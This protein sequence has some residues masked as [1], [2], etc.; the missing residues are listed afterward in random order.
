MGMV[1][2]EFISCEKRFVT[3]LSLYIYRYDL[4]GFFTVGPRSALVYFIIIFYQ[5]VECMNNAYF[6]MMRKQRQ[7]GLKYNKDFIQ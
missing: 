7:C 1:D 3:R 5:V 2:N 6:R 4:H